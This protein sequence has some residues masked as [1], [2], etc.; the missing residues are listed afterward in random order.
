MPPWEIMGTSVG[1]VNPAVQGP[2]TTVGNGTPHN[3]T[4]LFDSVVFHI[5]IQIHFLP[6]TPLLAL[7]MLLRTVM[8]KNSSLSCSE[9]DI[10]LSCLWRENTENPLLVSGTSFSFSLS[11]G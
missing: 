9:H 4:F 3:L 8:H 7:L 11:G 2:K 6:V 1:Y 10:E 5:L